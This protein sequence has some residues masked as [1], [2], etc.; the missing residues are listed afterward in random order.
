MKN[1][2]LCILTTLMF[3]SCTDLTTESLPTRF[4]GRI[5]FVAVNEKGNI[6]YSD[7]MLMDGEGNLLKLTS[8]ERCYSRRPDITRD[9]TRIAFSSCAQQYNNLFIYHTDGTGIRNITNDSA[10]EELP[11]WSPDGRLLGFTSF[12]DGWRDLFLMNDETGEVEKVTQSDG[13]YWI[14]CW[15]ADNATLF[16]YGSG[17]HADIYSYDLQSRTRRQLTNG[18]GRKMRPAITPDGTLIA[19]QREF[20]L[21]FLSQTGSQDVRVL[22][23]PDSLREDMQW[24]A[25][26]DFL[27]FQ[28]FANG[29]WDIY[30]IDR[31]GTGLLNLTRDSFQGYTPVISP[32]DAEIAYVAATHPFSKIYIMTNEGKNKRP[33]TRLHQ[34]EFTP[35]W[36]K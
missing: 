10:I 35:S 22:S 26:G 1:F 27:V 36:G 3:S 28:A 12:R 7:V 15:S 34:E 25:Q 31:Y 33:L 16:Y 24:S 21:H 32:D 23:A 19:Y 8:A 11:S 20:K 18:P 5:A 2:T 30:R 13:S 29:R 6:I 4:N 17:T 14:G 9:G